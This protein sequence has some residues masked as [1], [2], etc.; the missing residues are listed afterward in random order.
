[1]SKKMKLKLENLKIQSFVTSLNN[2]DSYGVKAGGL[3][4][5][6]AGCANP[7]QG[8]SAAGYWCNPT[9]ANCS[10]FYGCVTIQC[11]N[12]IQS[13]CT[14]NKNTACRACAW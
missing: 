4:T 11:G 9:D 10:A 13:E 8:C 14:V 12:S 7:T 1:M 3:V 6:P 5:D 2:E